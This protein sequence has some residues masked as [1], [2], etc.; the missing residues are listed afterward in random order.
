MIPA[1]LDRRKKSREWF[2]HNSLAKNTAY[3]I[4]LMIV[5]A[6]IVVT[7]LAFFKGVPAENK[8][9]VY[10]AIGSLWTLTGT[11]INF[12]RGASSSSL[13]KTELLQQK[14]PI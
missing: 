10:M 5:I 13:A 11:I 6:S 8:E 2:L 12:H 4:D 14:A 1:S 3:A 7:W 9:L